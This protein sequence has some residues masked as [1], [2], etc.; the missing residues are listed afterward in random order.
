MFGFKF[1]SKRKR[2]ECV[3]RQ[4]VEF[5]KYVSD[6]TYTTKQLAMRIER[7]EDSTSLAFKG[8]AKAMSE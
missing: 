3:E 8:M 1:I 6:Q 7:I 2:R 5:K 4:I